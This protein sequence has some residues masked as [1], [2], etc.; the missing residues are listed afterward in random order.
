MSV[1]TVLVCGIVTACLAGNMGAQ[2][3]RIEWP[4]ELSE[5]DRRDVLALAKQMGIARP[6]TVDVG[7]VMILGDRYVSIASA[8]VADGH[9]LRRS[10]I[11]VARLDW[12][13]YDD[14]PAEG[15]AVRSGNWFVRGPKNELIKWRIRDGAWS[16]DIGFVVGESTVTYDSAEK[17]VLAIR[18]QTLTNR[19]AERKAGDIASQPPIPV[20]DASHIYWIQKPFEPFQKGDQ[21]G[22]YQISYETG[23][24]TGLWLI[25]RVTA[26]GVE[27]VDVH[28]FII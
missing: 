7:R 20:L 16:R 22:L 13:E 12:H 8:E 18:R 26:E 2:A 23:E 17:V 19:Q 25:V 11:Y 9:E 24:Y 1:R 28:S 10:L 21:A 5:S 4:A 3:V 27:L 15:R 6:A 14:L